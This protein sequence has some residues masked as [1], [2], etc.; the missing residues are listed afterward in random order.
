M[1]TR[2]FGRTGHLSTIAI[3][4]TAALYNGTPEMTDKAMQQ[5]LE[6]GVNHID[7]APGYNKAEELMGPWIEKTR[8][9]FFLGCKTQLRAKS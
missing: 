1:Q 9:Q 6:A 3:F 5:I 2:R 8:E 7:I 4:G